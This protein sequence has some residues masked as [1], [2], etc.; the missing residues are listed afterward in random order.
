[1]RGM[2][3]VKA[4]FQDRRAETD[5]DLAWIPRRKRKTGEGDAME[6]TAGTTI[7]RFCRTLPTYRPA[8]FKSLNIPTHLHITPANHRVSYSLWRRQLSKE[9][10]GD[11][12]EVTVVMSPG[13]GRRVGSLS[14]RCYACP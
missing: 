8:C 2:Q 10:K 4:W 14:P 9:K 12:P 6:V 1:M 5:E 7:A 3:R 13:V 11:L